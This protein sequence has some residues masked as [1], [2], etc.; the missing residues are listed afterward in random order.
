MRA[1]ALGLSVELASLARGQRQLGDPQ[2]RE[3]GEL[4]DRPLGEAGALGCP[5]ARGAHDPEIGTRSAPA[6]PA[7]VST[8]GFA[9]PFSMLD[10]VA[11]LIPVKRAS[12]DSERWRAIRSRRRFAASTSPMSWWFIIRNVSFILTNDSARTRP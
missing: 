12:S 11:L 1:R 9:R 2:R 5:R 7:S 3:S 4:V 10:S 8:V 6:S